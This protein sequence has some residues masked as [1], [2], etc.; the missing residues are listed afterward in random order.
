MFA[1]NYEFD[2][3]RELTLDELDQVN[4]GW[5]LVGLGIATG[6]LYD[7]GKKAASAL[8]DAAGD[9]MNSYLESASQMETST[10]YE[11]HSDYIGIGGPF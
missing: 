11:N 7:A 1:M 8:A 10:D 6:L 2:G 5:R 9:A 3:V 4:G